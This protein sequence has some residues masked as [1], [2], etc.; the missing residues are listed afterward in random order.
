MNPSICTLIARFLSFLSF[1]FHKILTLGQMEIES[2]I[3]KH[4]ESLS[5]GTRLTSA[6]I[7]KGIGGEKS[8]V[9]SYLYQGGKSLFDRREP[10]PDS[11]SKAP[12]YS[13]RAHGRFLLLFIKTI[14]FIVPKFKNGDCYPGPGCFECPPVLCFLEHE[15]AVMILL[16]CFSL[17]IEGSSPTEEQRDDKVKN[18]KR[19]DRPVASDEMKETLRAKIIDHFKS[20][21]GGT[22][23]TAL[24][25]AKALD[26]VQSILSRPL[27]LPPSRCDLP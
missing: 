13:L 15:H 12:T 23:L 4:F 6:Q 20:L 19:V 17:F 26:K 7:A 14:F 5:P 16:F 11:T 3:V 9:N 1:L 21:P 24:Q 2:L 10:G 22:M 8:K 18:S 25:I 27:S